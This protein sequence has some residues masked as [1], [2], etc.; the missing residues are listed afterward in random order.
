MDNGENYR[1]AFRNCVQRFTAP[2][3]LPQWKGVRRQGWP[4]QAVP[5]NARFVR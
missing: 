1:A 4:D 5:N 3:Y 2:Q